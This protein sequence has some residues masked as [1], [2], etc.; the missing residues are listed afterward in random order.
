M[1][2]VTW[3]VEAVDQNVHGMRERR[4]FLYVVVAYQAK[5]AA[6][7]KYCGFVVERAVFKAK[8]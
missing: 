5:A 8:N 1:R 2:T 6:L 7:S 4:A 3:P